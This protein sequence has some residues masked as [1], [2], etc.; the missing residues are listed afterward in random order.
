[1]RKTFCLLALLATL[2]F[3]N[4]SNTNTNKNIK[5]KENQRQVFS[6]SVK[7][8]KQNDPEAL[9]QL[10]K[11]YYEGK[12]VRKSYKKALQYLEKAHDLGYE[13]ATYNLGIIYSNSRTPYHSY[14]KAYDIFIELAEKGNAA[15][16]NRVGMFLTL[17]MGGPIDFKE[18]VK[19]YEKSSKQGYI[20]A[21]CNLASMYAGGMGVFTNFG[22]AHAFAKKGKE[23]RNPICLKVWRDYNLEK[24]NKDK[25]FKFKFYNQP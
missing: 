5:H 21:Q 1:M 16:Q 25:G 9:F 14:S 3:A 19:W 17:G 22:R 23:L 12:I 8:A 18:A 11:F 10:G 4:H 2:G 20:T 13:K 24:F 6:R 7:L 15:A